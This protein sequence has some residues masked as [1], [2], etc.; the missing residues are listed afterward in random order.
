MKTKFLDQILKY[1][2]SQLRSLF[3]Y[4]DYGVMGDSIIAWEGPCDVSLDYMV[5]G[6]D[7][8]ENSQIYS[9]NMIH[10]IIEIFGS[11]LKEMTLI[12]RLFGEIVTR[13][14]YDYSGGQVYLCREGND[15]YRLQ[16]IKVGQESPSPRKNSD[17]KFN[18]SVATISPISGLIH[19]GLN[20]DSQGTPVKTYSLKKLAIE[21]K[22]SLGTKDLALKL[23]DKF[24]FEYNDLQMATC[25]VK[26]VK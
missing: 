14:V 11:S 21:S 16:S 20:I 2:G 7:F 9:K 22:Y 24:Q 8:K 13:T 5:D 15:L 23:M 26:W 19:F 1:D 6:Q 12:Q 17:E 25:K 18:V 3:A 10:F 4:L